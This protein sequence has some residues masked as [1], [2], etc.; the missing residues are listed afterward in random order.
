[1]GAQDSMAG[2]K[3]TLL[4]FFKGTTKVDKKLRLCLKCLRKF[5]SRGRTNRICPRCTDVNKRVRIPPGA[6]YGKESE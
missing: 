2:M 4:R 6:R 5:K 1:M 3:D